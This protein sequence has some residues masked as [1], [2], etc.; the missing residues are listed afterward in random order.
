VLYAASRQLMA[1]RRDGCGAPRMAVNISGRH[2]L[3]ADFVDRLGAI[4]G[5]TGLAALEPGALEIEITESTLVRVEES[6]V[7][8][9]RIKALGVRIAV[10]DFGMG[11]SSLA[12][13]RFLPV[14]TLK[15]DR[16]FI[17]DLPG[18]AQS[19]AIVEAVVALGR[20]LHMEIVGEGVED[21]AQRD[22]LTALG[23]DAIQGYFYSR[24]LPA[25]E[26]A[27]LLAQGLPMPVAVAA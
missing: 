12:H 13:L 14:D 1:W 9:D 23:C 8:L 10:D 4:L 6:R 11:Y 5:E 26:L 22:F 19:A 17:K 2:L 18:N 27:R 3:R 15:I 16:A 7:T 24:P 20:G 25:A 21:A